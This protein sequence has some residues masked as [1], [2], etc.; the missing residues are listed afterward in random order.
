MDGFF[1]VFVNV[2]VPI[3]AGLV[4]FA[5]ARYVKHIAPMRTLVTGQLTYA[6]A[7][8]GFLF[9]GFY[10]A[11][12]PVQIL[13]GPH[14][15]PLIIN[16]L[17]EFLMI[18]LFGPAVVIAILSLVFGSDRLPNAL[19]GGVVLLGMMLATTFV[20]V[21]IFAIGG[22]E[23]IFR[24]GRWVANDGLWF[25]TTDVAHAKLMGMLFMIRF[26]DPVLLVFLSG[27]LVFW[28][29][30][31][32]PVDKKLLYDN[33]PKKLYLLAIACFAFSLSMLS[34]GL[35]FLVAHIPNQWW[36][37]YLGSLAAGFLETFSLALPLKKGVVISEHS[38]TLFH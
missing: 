21:N 37:Y 13:L 22:S 3:M 36:I 25:K 11:T 14:P 4:F 26:V 12:R 23:E 38:R 16:N 29:A 19:V 32:Y 10:L 24:I 33:M 7:Y 28:H 31:H 5:L 18:G 8:W 35:I 17:R 20:V 15:W 27:T 9:L 2:V 30:R 34:V 1:P 6:G